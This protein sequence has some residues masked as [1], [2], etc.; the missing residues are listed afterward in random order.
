MSERSSVP[1]VYV[2]QSGKHGLGLFAKRLIETGVYIGDYEGTSTEENG[3]HVLWVEGDKP[4][5]W[6]GID[7]NNMLRFLNHSSMPNA[8]MD[9]PSLYASRTIQAGEEIT[10]DYGEEFEAP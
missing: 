6:F 5:D 10:I 2:D 9:G 7:G 1:G 8:E 3:M 4:G